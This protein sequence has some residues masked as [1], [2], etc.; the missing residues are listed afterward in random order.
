MHLWNSVQNPGGIQ[1]V[2]TDGGHAKVLSIS[3]TIAATSTLWGLDQSGILNAPWYGGGDKYF[4]FRFE[5]SGQ[6]YYGWARVMIPSDHLSFTIKDYAY[7]ATPN[8]SIFAGQM[9]T[10]LDEIKQG[11]GSS[12]WFYPN[13]FAISAKLNV[14][15]N[16]NDARL[17]IYDLTGKIMK[18]FYPIS[19]KQFTIDR[20][21]LPSG[22]YFYELKD[23]MNFSTG[24]L[25]IIN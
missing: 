2:I 3:D 25:I 24:K 5:I 12:V 17:I 15:E 18:T 9:P 16:M 20:E 23:Q 10:G 13:P 14:S 22:L 21:N 11:K 8:A 4:G 7:N 1:Q 19:G 6:W